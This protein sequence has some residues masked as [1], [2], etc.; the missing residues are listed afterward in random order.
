[1][2][3]PFAAGRLVTDWMARSEAEARRVGVR[4]SVGLE[5]EIEVREW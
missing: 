1:M 3:C 4:L 5:S 2:A